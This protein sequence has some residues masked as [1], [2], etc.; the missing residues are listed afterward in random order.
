[1]IRSIHQGVETR[2]ERDQNIVCRAEDHLQIKLIA[3]VD[4]EELADSHH[5]KNQVQNE[6]DTHHTLK[7]ERYRNLK[8][9]M[10]H[11]LVCKS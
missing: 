7:T 10:L 4:L 8:M 11:H 2:A 3:M 9:E 5:E 6:N 1:M